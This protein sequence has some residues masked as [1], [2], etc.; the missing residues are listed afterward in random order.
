MNL[1]IKRCDSNIELISVLINRITV[2]LIMI[3]N[4]F[5]NHLDFYFDQKTEMKQT[6]PRIAVVKQFFLVPGKCL[7][8][9]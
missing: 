1:L 6:T 4:I 2:N 7:R 5:E 8:G 9:L 3:L